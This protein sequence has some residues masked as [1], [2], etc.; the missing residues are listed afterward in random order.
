MGHDEE[1]HHESEAP[2]PP[3]AGQQQ[4]ATQ[5]PAE[6]EQLQPP[7]TAIGP[8]QEEVTEL[9]QEEKEYYENHVKA[10]FL[11]R[12]ESGEMDAEVADGQGENGGR[13]G[14]DQGRA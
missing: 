12:L 4:P 7:E 13:A 3:P 11:R 2:A 6:G 9:T 1:R 5:A 8:G 10:E 14:E